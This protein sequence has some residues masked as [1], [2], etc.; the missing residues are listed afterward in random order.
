[1]QPTHFD[2][3]P[4][5]NY[6]R[7]FCVF[8]VTVP[9]DFGQNQVVWTFRTRGE[10]VS[11]VGKLIPPY[12]WTNRTLGVGASWRRCSSSRRRDPSSRAEPASRHRPEGWR[13]E[14]RSR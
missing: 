3:V 4:E 2:P 8:T 11:T 10:A 9:E 1:M 7:R 14:I 12:V 13:S 6:R 5:A